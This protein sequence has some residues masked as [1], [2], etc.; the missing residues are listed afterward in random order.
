MRQ[1]TMRQA[2]SAAASVLILLMLSVGNTKASESVD[3]AL[4]WS[5]ERDGI[6]RGYLL[7]TIHSEDPRVLDYPESFIRQMISNEIF[8]MEMVP[9]MPTLAKLTEY[10]HYQDGTTLESQI[11]PE[12]YARL[13]EILSGYKVPADWVT[14]MKVWAAMM[15]LS[16]PP[17]QTGLFMDFSLSLRASGSG[18]KVKGLETLEEQL[19]FL[20]QMTMEQQLS[21]LD[22]AL[23]EYEKVGDIHD[24]M[25]DAYLLGNQQTLEAISEEQMA[26]LDTDSRDYFMEQ[27]IV[28][29]NQRMLTNILSLLEE[30]DV[31]VAVGA[32]HLPGEEGLVQLLRKQGF[33]LRPLPLPFQAAP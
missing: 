21:L 33:Q 11:G 16:V 12:R 26:E 13:S 6:T 30:S 25:V 20:E 9:D 5:I 10:M 27:G 7:G 29:R 14:R 32:L 2:V 8:A 15:T 31:F 4:Y 18:M 24:E 17:A 3:T 19:A 22:Q 23:D 1:I 28:V